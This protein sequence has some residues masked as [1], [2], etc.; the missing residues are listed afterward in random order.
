MSAAQPSELRYDTDD[1]AVAGAEPPS[2]AQRA[3][4]QQR[5][6]E[7]YQL[8]LESLAG[9]RPT[10]ELLAEW[11]FSSAELS[12]IRA[13]V[14]RGALVEL[15]RGRGRPRKDNRL[16]AV[17]AEVDRLNAELAGMAVQVKLLAVKE[18]CGLVGP[19]RAPQVT[20][21]G[22]RALVA[23]IDEACDAGMPVSQA[24]AI[25]QLPRQRYYAW[26]ASLSQG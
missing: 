8:F 9:R 4:A 15:S 21:S 11:G 13:A 26:R 19:I 17:S 16:K 14:R 18:S 10:G 22:R 23:A 3:G 20:Y 7:K 24:C 2:A 25:L 12:R 5:A 1:V 6:E